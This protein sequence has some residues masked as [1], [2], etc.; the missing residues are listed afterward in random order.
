MAK[1]KQV[2]ND[3]E[4]ID[5]NKQIDFHVVGIGASAGGLEA[6]KVFFDNVP[7]DFNHA[8]VIIQHLSPDYK[9]LMAE[10]LSRNTDLPIQEAEDGMKVLPGHVYLIPAKKNMT[11]VA[12]K[13]QLTDK[14]LGSGLNLPIDIFFKSLAENQGKKAIGIVLSGTGSDGTRGI[15]AIKELGGMVMVQNPQDAKFDGMPNS[16]IAT[17]LVD[18]IL[19][20][21]DIPVELLNFINHPKS[22]ADE[23]EERK[24]LIDKDF[25][26]VL[27]F[28]HKKTGIDF[29]SYKPPTLIRRIIRR[30]SVNQVDTIAHYLNY[31]YENNEE[32]EILYREFLIGVT[33]FFR[34]NDAF[35]YINENVIPEIFK[36]KKV[37]EPVKVW[38]VGCSTG[39]EAYSLAIL[40]HEY[41]EKNAINKEV[42]VFA[43]DLDLGAIQKANKG[44][45]SES[46]IADLSASRI[47]KYFLK[48]D[49]VYHISPEIRRMIIFS[50]HNA[51][52]DP[53]FTKMDLITCRNLLIYL[54]PQLQ[55][56][57]LSNLHYATSVNKFLFLGPSETIGNLN[58]S[59]AVLSRKW[60]VFKNLEPARFVDLYNY[61][62]NN[63]QF[64]S[65]SLPIKNQSQ[66][67]I[68]HILS[69][70]LSEVL[71][72]EFGAASA[73][74]DDNFELISADGNFKQYLQLPN[75]RFRSF[76]I[77][78]MLPSHISIALSTAIRKVEKTG[79]KVV[80]RNVS[81]DN[82]L[83]G[84]II[85]ISISPVKIKSSYRKIFLILFTK[86]LKSLDSVVDN[87]NVIENA[88]KTF[89]I[90]RERLMSLE[91]ELVDTKANLQ[92]MIEEV[93]TSNEELQATNEEL[94]AS[95]EELQ[96]TNEELQSVNEELYTVNSEHQEKMEELALLNDDL[97]NLINSIDIGVIFLDNH[98]KIRKFSPS[99]KQFFNIIHSDIGRP[100][101][102]FKSTLGEVNQEELIDKII[103]VIREQETLQKEVQ[104][105]DSKWYL[106][107]IHPF[108]SAKTINE[109]VVIS[110][111]DI[112]HLKELELELNKSN[113]FFKKIS[114]IV[115]GIIYILNHETMSNE[116]VSDGLYSVLGYSA[117]EIQSLGGDLIDTLIH[118][119]DLEKVMK[120]HEKVANSDKKDVLDLEY[121]VKHK[122]GTYRW[123][124][125]KDTIFETVPD[126]K[127]I[128]QIGVATD[129]TR[130]KEAE[131]K[132]NKA[133]YVYNTIIEGAM[134]GYWDWN[135]PD[136]TEFMS[137]TFK[138]MF[139]Y[140]DH[141]VPNTPNWWQEHIHPDD[142]P[143]VLE[144]FNKHVETKGEFPYDN[145]VRYFHKDGSIVWVYCRGKVIEWGEDGKPV[146][147]VGTH[148]DITSIKEMVNELEQFAYITT[149]DI[150]SPITNIDNYLSLL[151]KDDDIT[152]ERSQQALYWIEQSIEQAKQTINDLI[153][154]V[155]AKKE[156]NITKEDVNLA[157][158]YEYVKQGLLSEIQNSQ[159]S[160]ISDFSQANTVSFNKSK[161]IS[162]VQNLLSNALKYRDDNRKLKIEVT[163]TI[164]NNYICLH[165]K[166]NGSGINLERDKD[167]VFGL[168]KRAHSNI[169]GNGVG[170]Y[171]TKQSIENMG[172]KIEVESEVGVG[173][174]FKVYFMN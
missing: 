97:E 14:P 131:D 44:I 47:K 17:G 100:I 158:V 79:K 75:K 85:N 117:K 53:P 60:K 127:K 3:L 55:Q 27:A 73:Y 82:A 10:L 146:R 22:N 169:S 87:T 49:E 126:T 90:E 142:L 174:I 115:P 135:I 118:P 6:L 154:V 107:R 159:A 162:V 64:S 155:K 36:S 96:S 133:N 148:V 95:N 89:N 42:K 52:Q 167:K 21:S 150:K 110:F 86:E 34:D 61:N 32:A 98:L 166:D 88:H 30:M 136:N 15:R 101:T 109:G 132:I 62:R 94:L 45:F 51:A 4:K 130:I 23:E 108:K 20:T 161:A 5:H 157:E 173:T 8:L 170:L 59:F 171:L 93:E 128:K 13:L 165:V 19:P 63:T 125:T 123:L 57:L 66:P 41:M 25:N 11:F 70:T 92:A 31:L 65:L 105:N 145:E 160:I 111:V 39:E 74:V 12:G 81:T 106:K 33:K 68:E 112:T 43:T 40:I 50:Q 28:V 139:G 153:L 138:K 37:D 114:N 140:E 103:Y 152:K 38:S 26:R 116:Y 149:H 35:K 54:Q 121:R 122:D 144:S 134:A 164:E 58:Q 48:K 102:H 156:I 29:S 2:E 72:E 1:S 91:Q 163:T 80:Y 9:S 151:R 16:A 141:E 104:I 172:G 78:K 119:D 168:F 46:I 67:R 18:Y 124:L 24:F 147:M 129:I 99:V 71:L 69:E 77:L 137:P 143:L 120:H 56:K 83:N 76:N 7:A 113:K 84:D